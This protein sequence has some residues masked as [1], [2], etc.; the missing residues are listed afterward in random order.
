MSAGDRLTVPRFAVSAI[1]KLVSAARTRSRA[2]VIVL[3]GKPMME[4]D[5]TPA[6]E[7]LVPRWLQR[8]P[9]VGVHP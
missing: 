5:G 4:D 2:S 7:R 1:D 6:T 8:Q 9:Y 3:R